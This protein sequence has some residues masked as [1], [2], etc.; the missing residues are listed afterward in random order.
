MGVKP[1]LT[2]PTKTTTTTA[3][4]TKKVSV[5]LELKA[6]ILP[7][8]KYVAVKPTYTAAQTAAIKQAQNLQL[9]SQLVS[10]P[11]NVKMISILRS[12]EIV[13]DLSKQ[14]LEI[15][16]SSTVS[17]LKT[18]QEKATAFR[19]QLNS[20]LGLQQEWTTA[21]SGYL[22]KISGYE[23]ELGKATSEGAIAKG[24]LSFVTGEYQTLLDKYQDLLKNPPQQPGVDIFGG[25][26]DTLK[27]YG[28]YAIVGVILIVALYV[29][30]KA[31]RK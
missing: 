16:P 22:Q 18:D 19:D 4:T 15:I 7:V 17:E 27:K 25:L 29:G 26:G 3:T 30:V 10:A 8:S 1:T 31:F 12:A 6:S 14:G 5:P 28:V 23:S 11:S 20:L 13:K 9:G 2:S 24:Q 21:Q